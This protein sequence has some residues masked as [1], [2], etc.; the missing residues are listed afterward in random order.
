MS[1]QTLPETSTLLTEVQAKELLKGAGIPVTETWLAKNQREAVSLAKGMGF[2]VVMKIVSP[3][4]VHKSDAGGV[5][6][7][8]ANI[9]QLERAYREI[10][11]SVREKAPSAR[12]AGVSIQ[13]MAPPGVELIIGMSKDPQFGPVIMF[14]L[15]GILVEVLKDVS[16]RLVPLTRRDAA[17]M[18]REIKGFAVLNGFRG[19]D[20]VDIP[21]L[22]E[23][24]LKVSDFIEKTPRIKEL[25]LNPLFGYRNSILAVD[26]RIV[27]EAGTQS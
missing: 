8:L 1:N 23:L 27:L 18:V 17:E 12:I 21:S 26:A 10:M 16:F 2:P 22:E 6:L 15:G 19:Q 7:R 25:D 11:S 5:K 13:K 24:L 9:S 4:I 20:P 3:D 14:G